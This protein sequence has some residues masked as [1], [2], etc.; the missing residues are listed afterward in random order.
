[1]K[2]MNFIY[3]LIINKIKLKKI[4]V[5]KQKNYLRNKFHRLIKRKAEKRKTTDRHRQTTLKIFIIFLYF[6]II[7]DQV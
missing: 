7:R 3:Q 4:Y 2:I 5:K 1:M 6:Q